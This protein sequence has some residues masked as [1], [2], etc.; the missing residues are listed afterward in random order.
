MVLDAAHPM[1]TG[2][3]AADAL[4]AHVFAARDSSAI[5]TV[6]VGGRTVVERGRHPLRAAAVEAF[7]AVRTSLA[8][9]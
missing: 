7:T 2:L 6:V 8:S 5:D 9:G 3:A 1:L 4:D